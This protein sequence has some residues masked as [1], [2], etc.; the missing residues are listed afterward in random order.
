M[1]TD[2]E[3]REVEQ[4]LRKQACRKPVHFKF[5]LGQAQLSLLP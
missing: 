3:R 2:N 5:F 4:K 1:I